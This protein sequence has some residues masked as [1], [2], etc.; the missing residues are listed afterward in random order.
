MKTLL[1]IVKLC[2]EFLAKQ[3]ISSPKREAELLVSGALHISRLDLY[4]NFERPLTEEELE[5]IRARLKRRG[6]GEPLPYIEGSL[7]FYRCNL[8]VNSSVLIPRQET[9]VLVDK[10]V[11]ELKFLDLKGKRFLDL[12]TGSGCIGLAIKKEFPD[13]EVILSDISDEALRVAQENAKRNQ[14]QVRLLHG[15]FFAPLKLERVDFIAC[16]PPYISEEEYLKLSPEVSR[17]E[18][19]LALKGG[20]DGLKFYKKLKEEL[21]RH[22]YPQGKVWLEIGAAQGQAVSALFSGPIWKK[23]LLE[24]DWSGHDRFIS[25]EFE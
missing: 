21:P 24:K 2:E 9:E 14:L 10:I 13:L 25:L 23:V 16:N 6:Q 5:L 11:K 12:C 15:D 22:L 17:F 4:V 19:T 8:T 7:E 18:P 1:E 20:D 3:G